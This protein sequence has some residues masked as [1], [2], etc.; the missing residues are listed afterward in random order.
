MNIFKAARF[1]ILFGDPKTSPFTGSEFHSLIEDNKVILQHKIDAKTP[2]I[3]ESLD[4]NNLLFLRQV[5]G[6]DGA[7]INPNNKLESLLQDGDY[8]ITNTTNL[9]I[10]VLT[11]DCLP[12]VFYDHSNNI[13]AIAH[14]G[15]PGSFAGISTKVICEMQTKFNSHINDIL[16]F[17]GP[18][19]KVCCYEVQKDFITKLD[20]KIKEQTIIEHDAKTFFNLPLYNVLMLEKIGINKRNINFDYNFCTICSLQYCSY[21]R[22]KELAG[23]QMTIISLH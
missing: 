4:I 18:S 13:A 6:I 5:H 16:I 7:I 15:W 3:Q 21:R 22:D 20:T 1:S 23:R 19:A 2:F 9:G 11:A 12:I 8:I 10:G 17:F 14:A